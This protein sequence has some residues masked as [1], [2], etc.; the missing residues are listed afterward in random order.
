MARA[1]SVPVNG[2]G[3]RSAVVNPFWSDRTKAKTVL[4][5]NRPMDLP[6]DVEGDSSF[7]PVEGPSCTDGRREGSRCDISG[8]CS[9][10]QTYSDVW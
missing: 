3:R 10:S 1:L 8:L 4:R 7:E 2:P 6:M 9:C 5:A